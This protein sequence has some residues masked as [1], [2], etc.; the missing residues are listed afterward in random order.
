MS[1]IAIEAFFNENQ[2]EFDRVK[3]PM[4]RYR[5]RDRAI[6]LYCGDFFEFEN[7]PFNAVFDRGSLVAI[8]RVA[9]PHYAAHLDSLMHHDGFR[10]LVTL[11]YDQ[12]RVAGPPFAV[13][14]DEVRQYWPDLQRVTEHDDI[15]NCPPKFRNAGLDQVIEVVWKSERWRTR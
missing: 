6:T 12:V 15:V 5:A 1:A 11:E 14:P 9:R 2:L 3:G 4:D 13:M 8:P 7:E 10:L